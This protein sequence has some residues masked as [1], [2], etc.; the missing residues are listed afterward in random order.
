MSMDDNFR[1]GLVHAALRARAERLG[2]DGMKR[3]AAAWATVFEI[4]PPEVAKATR[5]ACP[6]CRDIEWVC[7]NHRDRPWSEDILNG[8]QCGAG[9]PCVCNALHAAK[10]AVGK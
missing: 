10:E 3:E 5:E 9:A 8:C 4:A 6:I 7:E 2:P 1:E